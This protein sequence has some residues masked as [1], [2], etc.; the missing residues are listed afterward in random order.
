MRIFNELFILVYYWW[1]VFTLVLLMINERQAKM[2]KPIWQ[3][4]MCMFYLICDI[5]IFKEIYRFFRKIYR[6]SYRFLIKNRIFWNGYTDFPKFQVVMSA[7]PFKN[8]EGG[9]NFAYF[10]DPPIQKMAFS[11]PPIQQNSDFTT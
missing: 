3:C 1:Y 5:I 8:G 7:I 2:Y 9:R 11:R 6:F 4:L 10:R